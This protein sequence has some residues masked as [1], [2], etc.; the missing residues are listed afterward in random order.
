MSPHSAEWFL[1]PHSRRK[2]PLDALRLRAGSCILLGI[3]PILSSPIGVR[4]AVTADLTPWPRSHARHRPANAV[5]RKLPAYMPLRAKSVGTP[6]RLKRS[7]PAAHAKPQLDDRRVL[8]GMIFN[9][10]NVPRW[11]D[12]S[13]RALPSRAPMQPLEA[14]G[15]EG[16][17]RPDPDGAGHRECGRGKPSRST[18]PASS[19]TARR[20]DGRAKAQGGGNWAVTAIRAPE[21]IQAS[22][23]RFD[24]AARDERSPGPPE[25]TNSRPL[26]SPHR[27]R[28]IRRRPPFAAPCR[29]GTF[30][31]GRGRVSWC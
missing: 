18:R 3:C 7:F 31:A 25:R 12:T 11:R 27:G 20:P 22:A 19:P 1:E 17:V 15:T 9:N 21:Q 13:K 4:R 14:E 26:P 6:G 23:R 24:F 16:R 8:S 28:P 30:R 29:A 2:H 10:R 5:S